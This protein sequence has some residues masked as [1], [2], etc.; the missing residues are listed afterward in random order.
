LQSRLISRTVRKLPST[1]CCFC[2]TSFDFAIEKSRKF[3]FIAR[4]FQLHC[5][6]RKHEAIRLTLAACLLYVFCSALFLP[7][8]MFT[9]IRRNWIFS[10]SPDGLQQMT[11]IRRK[12]PEPEPLRKGNRASLL[13]D[14]TKERPLLPFIGMLS[15][16]CCSLLDIKR[17]QVK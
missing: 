6:K 17:L 1:S 8:P 15:C 3:P 12:E 9:P 7:L 2:Q 4:S 16:A 10:P 14:P 13:N 5:V 11:N